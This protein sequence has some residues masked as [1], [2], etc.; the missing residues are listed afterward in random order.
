MENTNEVLVSLN[1][2]LAT[3]FCHETTKVKNNEHK[4]NIISNSDA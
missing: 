4:G 2:M 1:L 3:R